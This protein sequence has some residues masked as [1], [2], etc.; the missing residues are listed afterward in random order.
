M[1]GPLPEFILDIEPPPRTYS[2]I[3]ERVLTT[4]CPRT[5]AFVNAGMTEIYGFNQVRAANYFYRASQLSPQ[6]PFPLFGSAYAVQM[7]FNHLVVSERYMLYS[8]QCYTRA[9]QLC[10]RHGSKYPSITK[11][12]VFA[13]GARTIKKG[14]PPFDRVNLSPS[15]PHVQKNMG[16]WATR[17][18]AVF[19][20]FPNDAD[21]CCLYA[22]SLMMYSPW[23]WWPDGSLYV[24]PTD[25]KQ[26]QRWRGD[27]G[28][29]ARRMT[30]VLELLDR[31]RL[32][33][34]TN[35]GAL[36]YTIHAVE[37]SPYPQLGLSAA[38][39]LEQLIP[40]DGPGH[41]LHMPA[42]IYQR[43]GLYERS[44]LTNLAAV[45]ADR[46]LLKEYQQRA[47]DPHSL[48]HSFYF[49]EYMAHNIHFMVIDAVM[50][51]QYKFALDWAQQLETHVCQFMD[52]SKGQ[53]TFLEH[54]LC[55]KPHVL[56][57]ARKFKQVLALRAWG[58]AYPQLE[59]EIAFCKTIAHIQ[60]G[61][62]TQAWG[63]LRTFLYLNRH[64]MDTK[65][66]G[67]EAC[68]CGCQKRH[69]GIV[70][71]HFGMNKY[72]YARGNPRALA[73]LDLKQHGLHSG[74]SLTLHN[75]KI[76]AR[77]RELLAQGCMEWFFNS[78]KEA[79]G[80]FR[81]AT[82]AYENLQYDEPSD[83][84]RPVHETYAAALLLEGDRREAVRIAYRGQLPYPNNP[85]LSEI[86]RIGEDDVPMTATDKKRALEML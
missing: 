57:L 3:A 27:D 80:A 43:V 19:R 5:A 74:T 73:K 6:E 71:P 77:I 31:A 28:S 36:H 60:L 13:L 35:I 61:Q 1:P 44:I 11:K 64:F 50:L 66:K 34:P 25:L 59:A 85:R 7:N 65:Y 81:A 2:N 29:K 56:L 4:E 67:G 84:I 55:V 51:G 15:Y 20:A 54:F 33:D 52:P 22:S 79:L 47:L 40:R 32:L 30:D 8:I 17:M 68:R 41:L 62:K 16:R 9:K 45:E 18:A 14:T 37:E 63:S 10:E 69:G 78:K 39:A 48:I 38:E 86:I 58:P 21:V 49:A 42:H 72:S 76:L 23:K 12:L 46:K 26:L 70:N 53:N 75:S 82:E 24:Q 83:Y